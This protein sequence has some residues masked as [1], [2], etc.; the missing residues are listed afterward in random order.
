M[1]PAVTVVAITVTAAR[2][3]AELGVRARPTDSDLKRRYVGVALNMTLGVALLNNFDPGSGMLSGAPGEPRARA[4]AR[5]R[6]HTHANTRMYMYTYTYACML[7][8]FASK[9]SV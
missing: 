9:C 6:T 7:R 3:A 1:T 8:V 4:R 5:A 2:R